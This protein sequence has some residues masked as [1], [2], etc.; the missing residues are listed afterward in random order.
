MKSILTIAAL[1]VAG[2]A[3][4]MTTEEYINGGAPEYSREETREILGDFG[5]LLASADEFVGKAIGES[6]AF[7]E[8]AEDK[9]KET[10]EKI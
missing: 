8:S 6:K 2:S 1:L 7:I 3:S 10:I 5:N 4:A 9:I